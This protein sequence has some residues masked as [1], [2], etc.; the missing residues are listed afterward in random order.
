MMPE[1]VF[2]MT[3]RLD[4]A[5]MNDVGR[6]VSRVCLE[7]PT[8]MQSD[9][10]ALEKLL[11]ADVIDRAAALTI[12][13]RVIANTDSVVTTGDALATLIGM[14]QPERIDGGPVQ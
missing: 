1:D 4:G 7:Y 3:L 13:V 14:C 6:A 12:L 10:R 5:S 11:K 8:I 9:A 2:Q